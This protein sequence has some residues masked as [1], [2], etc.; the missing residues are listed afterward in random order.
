[1]GISSFSSFSGLLGH[2]LTAALQFS[3]LP[4]KASTFIPFEKI[5]RDVHRLSKLLS[6]RSP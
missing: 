1:M 5:K 4:L 3:F 6:K 2:F